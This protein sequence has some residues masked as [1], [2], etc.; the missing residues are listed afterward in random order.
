ML[1]NAAV[2]IQFALLRVAMSRVPGPGPGP[3]RMSDCACVA[4]CLAPAGRQGQPAKAS[5][6]VR[7]V[8]GSEGELNMIVMELP[9][10]PWTVRKLA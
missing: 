7:R 6:A 4:R 10:L 3:V 9:P 2:F 1:V 5:P 8:M